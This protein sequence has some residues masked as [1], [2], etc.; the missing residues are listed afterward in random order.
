MRH[1]IVFDIVDKSDVGELRRAIIDMAKIADMSEEASGR[2]AIISNEMSTNILKHSKSKGKILIRMIDTKKN[3][4]I[5]IISLDKGIGIKNITNALR[6]GYSTAG[7]MGTGLGAI[8]RLSDQ[9]DIYSNVGTGTV[10]ISRVLRSSEKLNCKNVYEHDISAI[11]VPKSGQVVC[12]D[13]WF[14]EDFQGKK[15]VLLLDG[16]GHG[17]GASE[18]A[19]KAVSVFINNVNLSVEDIVYKLHEGLK[20]TR[21]AVLA[22]A[23][24]DSVNKTIKYAGI[25]NIC[26]RIINNNL[27]QN[28]ISHDG[29]VGE[30]VTI[31]QEYT[32][33]WP[34]D[35]LLI[36]NTD[37]LVVNNFFDNYPGLLNRSVSIISGVIYKDCVRGNDDST[38]MVI[39]NSNN[40]SDLCA[41]NHSC[42]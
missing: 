15:V 22:V 29:I 25:G 31:V 35:S 3:I 12:G 18:A 1:H 14:V 8:K 24:L 27:K 28:L 33:C 38:I 2:L 41:N 39:R 32:Y 4:G 30:N 9:F 13:D 36:M 11:S 42:Y 26:A 5:E 19:V 20:G 10:M 37:G 34:E 17:E 21:G 16:L 6:D 7:S 40:R 23:L